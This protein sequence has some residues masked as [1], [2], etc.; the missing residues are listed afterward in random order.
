MQETAQTIPPGTHFVDLWS[1]CQKVLKSNLRELILLT[2]GAEARKCP[3]LAC[4]PSFCR[5]LEPRPESAQI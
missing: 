2:S 1:Q 4:W 5:L 3:D